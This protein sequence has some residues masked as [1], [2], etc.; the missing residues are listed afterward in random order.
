MIVSVSEKEKFI[1]YILDKG[2]A[3]DDLV[4]S[5]LS[6]IA[7]FEDVLGKVDFLSKSPVANYDYKLFF[8]LRAKTFICQLKGKVYKDKK[9]LRPILRSIYENEVT[10]CIMILDNNHQLKIKAEEVC[11]MS[12][13]TKNVIAESLVDYSQRELNVL[14]LRELI[15]KSLDERNEEDFM[16]Y[17]KYLNELLN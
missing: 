11:T 3:R 9:L 6:S 16:K 8:N 5:F 13:F 15:D 7:E 14:R 10:V 12:A 1:R 17:T 2:Y 4:S